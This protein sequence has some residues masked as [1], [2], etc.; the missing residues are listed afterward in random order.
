MSLCHLM[1]ASV[2]FSQLLLSSLN[3]CHL[4]HRSFDFCQ[5]PSAPVSSLQL[6][7]APFSS[8]RT[9]P[10]PLSAPCRAAGRYE[11]VSAVCRSR[12]AMFPRRHDA[13]IITQS[14]S[15]AFGDDP[16]IYLYEPALLCY[17]GIMASYAGPRSAAGFTAEI[18]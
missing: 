2:R 7:S 11:T 15:G 12:A 8:C 17:G 3:T 5:L 10:A 13:I 14:L 6:L 1:S 4:S 9:M 16:R 18:I